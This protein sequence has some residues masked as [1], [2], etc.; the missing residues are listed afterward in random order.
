MEWTRPCPCPVGGFVLSVVI[1]CRSG[2][3]LLEQQL[4]ALAAQ[5]MSGAWEVVLADNM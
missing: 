1:P 2:L 4:A 5:E 3:A